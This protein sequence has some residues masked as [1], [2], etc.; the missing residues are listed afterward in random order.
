MSDEL[1]VSKML[2]ACKDPTRMQILLLLIKNGRTNVG[3]IAREFAITRPAIS[4]H[5]KVLK[6]ADV[7]SSS[8]EGQEVYY[9]PNSHEVAEVLRNLADKIDGGKHRTNR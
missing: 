2:E 3:D 4:H 9:W 6:D 8:K 1:R 5:L 7:L